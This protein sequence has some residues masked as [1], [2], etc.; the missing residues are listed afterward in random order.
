MEDNFIIKIF[1]LKFYF[2]ISILRD[3][4]TLT[5]SQT[6]PETVVSTVVV[7]MLLGRRPCLTRWGWAD[8][9]TGVSETTD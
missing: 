5:M 2:Y 9:S 6:R 1:N 7:T 4:V 8:D 3:F